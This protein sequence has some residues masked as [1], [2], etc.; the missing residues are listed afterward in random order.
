MALAPLQENQ[1]RGNARYGGRQKP[2]HRL[3]RQLGPEHR[4]RA[5]V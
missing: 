4:R 3:R 2:R 5:L 1:Q